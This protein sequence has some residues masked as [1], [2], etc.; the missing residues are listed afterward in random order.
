MYYDENECCGC[1]D[2]SCDC[3]CEGPRGPRG[4]RGATGATGNT[5]STGATGPTGIGSTGPTGVTGATGNTGNTGATGPT[6]P[7]GNGVD[8]SCV[9]QMVNILLQ[10]I[11]LYPSDT[12]IVAMESGNNA[13]GR[14]GSLL[15][16]PDYDYGLL[17][18]T[19]AQGVPQEAV[20]ICR[21]AS[22][23]ITSSVYNE[24]IT[25]LPAPVP[26]PTGCGA[27]CESAIRSYLPT[28][29]TGVDINA[30]GQTVGKGTVIRNE[31]G[32][33]VLVGPNNSDPTFISTCKAEIIT[34]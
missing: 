24:A 8:C 21:I 28:G 22:V 6:G 17:Q 3:C 4:F 32:M 30:G 14:A 11:Q 13:S 31:F 20:S 12:I 15:S 27:A 18:L 23:R 5:G 34:K 2:C 1:F 19:N 7:G 29:T 9:Q 33:V 10:I 26:A 25:Y 16:S